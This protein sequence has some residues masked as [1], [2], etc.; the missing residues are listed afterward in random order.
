MTAG[1]YQV[2]VMH[3]F[4]LAGLPKDWSK[5]KEFWLKAA[6]QKPFLKIG[7]QP[8]VVTNEGVASSENKLVQ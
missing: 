6:A 5:A 7:N 3:E 1:L 2:G 4:G 8:P